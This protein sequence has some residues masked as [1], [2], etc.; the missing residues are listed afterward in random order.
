MPLLREGAAQRVRRELEI[1]ISNGTRLPGE[2]LD[3]S[4]LMDRFQV[5]RTPVRTAILQL[6]SL[7]L[8]TIVPRSGTYV[9]RVS[10]QE[11]LSMLEVL[12]EMEAACVKLATRR[13]TTAQ[14]EAL[15]LLHANARALAEAEDVGGYERYNQELHAL[16]YAASLNTYLTDQILTLRR[17]TK[18]YRST[19]F[20]EPGRIRT[21]Y[22]QHGQVVAA[23]TAGKAEEA[24]RYML[25]HIGSS[26]QD[27]LEL[28]SRI[29]GHS[30]PAAV[31][32]GI[33]T[34]S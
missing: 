21:S 25:T 28:L 22:E 6:A 33:G 19:V 20:Q 8:I 24:A 1:E 34:P 31:A 29:P 10:P 2:P 17:R 13:I 4:E 27:F 9:S 3:E 7:G 32:T 30:A 12:A 15:T 23:I 26:S 5:S 11:L 14:R 18:I 16:I